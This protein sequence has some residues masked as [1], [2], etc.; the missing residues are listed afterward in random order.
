MASYTHDYEGL[1]R[2]LKSVQMQAMVA[3]RAERVEA[4]AIVNAPV[5]ETGEYKA[6][7]E[8]EVGISKNG[9]RARAVVRNTS[10]HALF[11]E[12]GN[13]T[14]KA[15]GHRTLGRALDSI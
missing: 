11:V 6:S 3:A 10:G 14:E 12:Y 5:G 8:S 9:T 13:G 4:A 7:F 15:P 1:G 2:L